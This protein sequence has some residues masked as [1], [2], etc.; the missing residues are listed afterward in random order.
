MTGD[1]WD[2][3]L[4][5]GEYILWQGQPVPGINWSDAL[6]GVT[7]FGIFFAAFAL[8]W[9]AGSFAMIL[10]SDAPL[11]LFLFP[12]FGLPF[13][14]IGLFMAFGRLI[15][16]DRV[17]RH[18]W[19]SVSTRQ[20]FVARDVLGKRRLDS[21]DIAQIIDLDL[22]D[23]APGSVLFKVEEPLGYR[24]SRRPGPGGMGMAVHQIGTGLHRLPDARAVFSMIR[25][26][27]RALRRAPREGRQTT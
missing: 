19:Y 21:F 18:T 13:L 16:D 17:R 5:E 20:I 12:L 9:M 3:L 8:F 27:Q 23:G 10:G 2:G 22:V 6:N 25:D 26:Q 24:T 4:A 11:P 14:A 1:G 7:L 15:W